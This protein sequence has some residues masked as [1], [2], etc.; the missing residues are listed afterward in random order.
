ME[1]ARIL[2]VE[3]EA[4]IAMELERELQSLG[5]EVTSIVDTSEKA[6]EKAKIDKPDIILMDIWIKGEMDGIE[7]AD[8]MRSRFEIPIIFSIT[9]LDEERTERAKIS[10]PFEYVLKPIQ[11]QDLKKTIEMALYAVKVD[12]EF[13]NA[14][15][16]LKKSENKY[17]LLFNSIADPVFIFDKKSHRILHCNQ[18]AL[19]LYGYTLDELCTMTPQQLHPADELE[20]VEK[21]INDDEDSSSHSYTHITKKG[22]KLY[23]DVH[24][25]EIEYNDQEAWISTIRDI[26]ELKLSEEALRESEERFR[27]LSDASFESIFL[28]DKG[29]CMEQNQTAVRM[30]GYTHPESIGKPGTNWIIPEHRERVKL[31][32]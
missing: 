1:K 30:F 25:G 26:T 3:D 27:Y 9:S 11:E 10:M 8:I 21:N 20:E 14:E 32:L 23:V 31:N 5:Y 22:G 16:T 2:I 4:I 29:I 7:A 24:T 28:S 12:T 6:I 17:H 18:S 13:R 15:Q 19:D